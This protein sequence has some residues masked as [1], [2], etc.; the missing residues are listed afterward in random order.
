MGTSSTLLEQTSDQRT[1]IKS[2]VVI[3]FQPDFPPYMGG[4]LTFFLLENSFI[5]LAE[6]SLSIVNDRK[7]LFRK[8]AMAKRRVSVYSGAFFI[9]YAHKLQNFSRTL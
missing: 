8:D 9:T 4:L 6:D 2:V 3:S 5:N 7:N 1:V